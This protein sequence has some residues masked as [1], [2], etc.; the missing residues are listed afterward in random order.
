MQDIVTCIREHV[1][2]DQ[3]GKRLEVNAERHLKSPAE[4][5]R[6]FRGRPEA[7]AETLRFAARIPSPWTNSNIIIPHEPVPPGKTADE[8]LRDLTE[9]G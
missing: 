4:M 3:A 5:A 8:H 1:T 2:L 9:A 7:I 6:L